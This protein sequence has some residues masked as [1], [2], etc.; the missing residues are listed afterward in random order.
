MIAGVMTPTPGGVVTRLIDPVLLE[1]HRLMPPRSGEAMTGSRT[2]GPPE[3]IFGNHE[4]GTR[5]LHTAYCSAPGWISMAP[6]SPASK[7][8]ILATLRALRLDPG[9]GCRTPK[10][11]RKRPEKRSQ[12]PK[13]ALTSSAA[14]GMAPS[15]SGAARLI[16]IIADSARH[17][18]PPA[19]R[20]TITVTSASGCAVEGDSAMTFC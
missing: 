19:G 4:D 15:S 12:Q 9:C 16:W 6:S 10:T 5:Q 2:L 11:R 8:F 18:T 20:P 3:M 17:T 1:P 13:P 14:S 7:P